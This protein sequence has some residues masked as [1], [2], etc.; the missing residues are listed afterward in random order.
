MI[1][2]NGNCVSL[3]VKL[4][5]KR[6]SPGHQVRMFLLISV[7]SHEMEPPYSFNSL[8]ARKNKTDAKVFRFYETKLC[9]TSD[10]GLESRRQDVLTRFRRHDRLSVVFDELMNTE[11]PATHNG[12][13]P[14]PSLPRSLYICRRQS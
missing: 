12:C 14:S 11:G 2:I 10:I 7:V 8:V 9:F 4:R 13:W 1:A 6:D 3:T 5:P